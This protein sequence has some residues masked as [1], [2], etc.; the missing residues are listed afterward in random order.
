MSF[1]RIDFGFHAV[2]AGAD[3]AARSAVASAADWFSIGYHADIRPVDFLG[4]DGA[5]GRGGGSRAGEMLLR[6]LSLPPQRLPCA[7]SRPP[8]AIPPAAA[9]PDGYQ[10][11]EKPRKPGIS[12]GAFIG[13]PIAQDPKSQGFP[14]VWLAFLWRR[15]PK[16]EVSEEL[17]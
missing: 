16:S 6:L 8:C 4:P 17:C 7:V 14:G 15:V 11:L 10:G 9:A 5:R 1:L 3:A 13:C 2:I 12:F